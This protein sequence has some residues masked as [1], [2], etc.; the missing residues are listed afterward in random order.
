MSE[1]SFSELH[2]KIHSFKRRL[3]RDKELAWGISRASQ[4]LITQALQMR[5]A[6]KREIKQGIE[7]RAPWPQGLPPS[8]RKKRL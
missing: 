5:M 4:E 2:S 7:G 1:I 8:Q 6:L 3:R